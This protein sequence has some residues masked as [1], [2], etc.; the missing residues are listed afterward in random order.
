MLRKLEIHWAEAKGTEGSFLRRTGPGHHST[1]LEELS[2]ID[3]QFHASDLFR[4][5]SF[6]RALQYLDIWSDLNDDEVWLEIQESCE[7][8][9]AAI[10]D[11]CG[12]TLKGLRLDLWSQGWWVVPAPGLHEL[13]HLQYLEIKPD[14]IE[15]PKE[16]EGHFPLPQIDCPIDKL[17]P[18]NTEVLKIGPYASAYPVLLDILERKAELVP[19][20]R[21]VILSVYYR[22]ESLAAQLTTAVEKETDTRNYSTRTLQDQT[23]MILEEKATFK[24]S[25]NKAT[26][27]FFDAICK[28]N[29]IELVVLYEDPTRKEIFKEGAGPALWEIADQ[30]I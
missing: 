6:P 21:K 28:H 23:R 26:F 24:P 5:L 15:A 14:H 30:V 8:Y 29:N 1:A 2:L 7:P 27:E 16:W 17:L 12:E 25:T 20:L 22:D 19:S 3:C 11:T 10:R 4:L 18:P 9:F 13:L